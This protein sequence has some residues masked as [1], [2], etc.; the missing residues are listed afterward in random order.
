M[1][2][3]IMVADSLGVSISMLTV[4][5]MVLLGNVAPLGMILALASA[6]RSLSRRS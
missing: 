3:T 1:E 6:K 2:V 4:I 5:A